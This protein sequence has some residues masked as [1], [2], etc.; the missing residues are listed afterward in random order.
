MAG[1]A[2]FH[3]HDQ[4]HVKLRHDGGQ[5]LHR[6]VRLYRCG[7][8]HASSVDHL[9][10]ALKLIARGGLG[11]HR[12]DVGAGVQ[13]P[14]QLVKRVRDHQMH[15]KRHVRDLLQLLD[16]GHAHGQVR[17]EVAVHDVD[18]HVSRAA[19][20]DDLDV[21]LQVHEVR[22]QNGRSDFDRLEHAR[23]LPLGVFVFLCVF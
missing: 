6:R 12:D 11:V 5:H 23:L 13:K 9:D 4:H 1:K 15:V 21:A 22:R 14:R 18:V 7:S 16:H 8:L 20:L 19:R 17:H 10:G 2:R 3:A